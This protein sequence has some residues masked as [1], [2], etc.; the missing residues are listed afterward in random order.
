MTVMA[1]WIFSQDLTSFDL[2]MVVVY[3][4]LFLYTKEARKETKLETVLW[5]AYAQRAKMNFMIENI[6]KS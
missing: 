2:C 4:T 5:Q 1:T 6:K 3:K